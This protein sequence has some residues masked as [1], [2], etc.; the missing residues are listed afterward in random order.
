VNGAGVEHGASCTWT[1]IRAAGGHLLSKLVNGAGVE[2]GASC[3]W[4][5]IRAAG[6]HLFSGL[7]LLLPHRHLPSLPGLLLPGTTLVHS[8]PRRGQID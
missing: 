6:G 3:T 4:T 8:R 1:G 5:G 2:H 7:L